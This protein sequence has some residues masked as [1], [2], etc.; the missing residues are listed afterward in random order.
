MQVKKFDKI[1]GCGPERLP[2]RTSA[3]RDI[4]HQYA[5]RGAFFTANFEFEFETPDVEE[6]TAR[7]WTFQTEVLGETKTSHNFRL[8]SIKAKQ[9][10]NF[11]C[12]R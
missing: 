2:L 1:W 10:L 3:R 4:F 12:N 7:F 5:V 11:Y 9:I 8:K 6:V